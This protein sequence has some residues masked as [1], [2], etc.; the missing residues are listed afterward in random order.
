MLIYNKQHLIGDPACLRFWQRK[1]STCEV[2]TK[3]VLSLPSLEK[4]ETQQAQDRGGKPGLCL[5]FIII[6]TPNTMLAEHLS[7]AFLIPKIISPLLPPNSV[8]N[9]QNRLNKQTQLPLQRIFA[10]RV[11]KQFLGGAQAWNFPLI[12]I[13]LD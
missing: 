10:S 7:A 8:S 12:S 9:N 1:F 5:Q 3:R 6:L 13:C 4:N 2:N 11:W